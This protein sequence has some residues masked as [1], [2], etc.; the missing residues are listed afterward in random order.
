MDVLIIVKFQFSFEILPSHTAA[1]HLVGKLYIS[2]IYVK[3]PLSL[4]KHAG[5]DSA[6]M[7]AHA[8]IYRRVRRLL[9]VSERKKYYLEEHSQLQELKVF[10]ASCINVCNEGD[11]KVS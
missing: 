11:K 10:H 1:L 3:L 2:R 6:R 5:K 7:D 4:T 9:Y 8:H